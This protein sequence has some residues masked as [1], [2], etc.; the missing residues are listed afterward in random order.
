MQTAFEIFVGTDEYGHILPDR[1]LRER[2]KIVTQPVVSEIRTSI[3]DDGHTFAQVC[4]YNSLR[5]E[6]FRIDGITNLLI[7]PTHTHTPG[8]MVDSTIGENCEII[9]AQ[10]D[11]TNIRTNLLRKSPR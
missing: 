6:M 9:F 5:E 8:F 10:N 11:S 1:M 7:I 4:I 3:G 2:E